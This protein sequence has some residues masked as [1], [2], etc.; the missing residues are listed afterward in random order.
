MF[1]PLMDDLTSFKDEELSSK[2]ADLIKKYNIALKMGNGALAQQVVVAL[3]VLQTENLRRQHEA[4]KR[5]LEKQ[6]K[7]LDG[8]INVG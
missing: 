5:L 4:S 3:D 2:I 6:N 7:D 1:N 8:L